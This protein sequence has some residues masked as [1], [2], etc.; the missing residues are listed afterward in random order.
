M[1]SIV[2]ALGCN[3][4]IQRPVGL[5]WPQSGN[6]KK[7]GHNTINQVERLMPYL[8][9]DFPMHHIDKQYRR[10]LKR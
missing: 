8:G 4:F 3:L 1:K 6:S 9:P 7:V 5:E 2:K 10:K